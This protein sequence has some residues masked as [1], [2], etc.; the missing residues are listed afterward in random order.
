MKRCSTLSHHLCSAVLVAVAA[1]GCVSRSALESADDE[2]GRLARENA[3]LAQ[4]LERSEAS[5]ASLQSERVQLID[6]MEDLRQANTEFASELS[7]LRAAEAA[8]SADLA[9]RESELA[10]NAEE[11]SRLSGTY[12]GLVEDLEAEVAAGQIQIEQLREGLLLNL[13][14]EILFPS[15]SARI[16]AGGAAVLQTVARRLESLPD[17]IEVRG[18]TDNVAIGSGAAFPSNWELAAA[19]AATVVRLFESEG[20][21]PLR[22]TVVSYGEHAPRAPNDSPEGRAKNRRIE[23]RLLP[24]AANPDRG[25][26]TPDEP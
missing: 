9:A 18:H 26:E 17:T 14:Q 6:E 22:L 8:L 5:S 1:S 2:R 19:R 11:L 23:I 10:K 24:V 12:S 20:I 15:G 13:S 21:D 7:R 25:D 3:A 16:N 4:K